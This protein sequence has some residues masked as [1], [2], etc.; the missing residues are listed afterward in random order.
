MHAIPE[1][2]KCRFYPHDHHL[3]SVLYLTGSKSVTCCNFE[4]V[5]VLEG[6]RF[7]DFLVNCSSRQTWDRMKTSG[8]HSGQT[9][10][11]S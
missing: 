3:V 9:T 6:R 4:H 7:V 10:T 8:S 11:D 5:P 2:S 1:C